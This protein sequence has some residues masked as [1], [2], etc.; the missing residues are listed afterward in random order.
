MLALSYLFRFVGLAEVDAGE[1]VPVVGLAGVAGVV[2]VVG[3]AGVVGV[4]P[5]AGLAGVADV[6][7]VAGLAGAAGVVPVV[8]LAGAVVAV[9][10]AGLFVWSAILSVKKAGLPSVSS[11][12][13]HPK[14]LEKKAT[15]THNRPSILST[16]VSSL[17]TFPKTVLESEP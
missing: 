4:V 6:V 14:P 2:P 15:G 5:V 11:F 16:T 7:P 13:S 8:G 3:L 9:G 12:I 10:V 17:K 1:V